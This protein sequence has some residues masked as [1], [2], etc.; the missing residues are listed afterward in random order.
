MPPEERTTLL[1]PPPPNPSL[2]PI[3]NIL[4][5]TPVSVLGP[6]IFTNTRKAWVPSGAR[7]IYGGAVIAQCL[8]A[9]QKTVPEGFLP[10][11]CHCYFLLAG[12]GSV[13]ILFHV[14][15][16]RD[17][18]SYVT[19]TVQARQRG[20]CIFTTTISFVREG[21]G[22]GAGK[23]VGVV[24][25]AVKLPEEA[26]ESLPEGE[27]EN[28]EEGEWGGPFQHVLVP[29]P[30]APTLDG[31]GNGN[32]NGN[33]GDGLKEPHQIRCQQW[34]R[35]RGK[36]SAEGGLPAHLNA[37]AYISDSGFVGTVA[38]VH[39]LWRLPFPPQEY[40]ALPEEQ[41]RRVEHVARHEGLG[42]DPEGWKALP[43]L[44]MMVSLD[45]SIYFHA[46]GRVRADE[47]MFADM[48]SPWAGDGRGFVTQRI[49]ARDGTL[50]ATCVQEGVV[51]LAP[52]PEKPKL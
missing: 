32:G 25:H 35:C 9:A 24:R 45:H 37:L 23:G 16:V 13:P 14:E 33:G 10:H 46:P 20:K 41:K 38:R 36:I 30:A 3:E 27:Y 49:F 21:A 31:K 15:R 17:G 7:G 22:A 43:H 1:R 19:R 42:D 4:Q 48:D 8:A 2:A 44:G 26:K 47:W 11:S 29:M 28:N 51:R 39:H 34:M 5:V 52:S 18:R 12:S 40:H 50:L 6:D